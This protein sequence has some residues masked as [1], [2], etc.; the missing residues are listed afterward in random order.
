MSNP[1]KL[2][3]CVDDLNR[4]I[5]SRKFLKI[6][7]DTIYDKEIVFGSKYYFKSDHDNFDIHI[8]HGNL[9][10]QKYFGKNISKY[11]ERDL[12]IFLL[13][14]IEW[15]LRKYDIKCVRVGITYYIK[16]EMESDSYVIRQ[17][18]DK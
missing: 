18:R 4:W 7:K 8:F 13:E 1:L 14:H 9:F 15:I 11:S 12:I 16:Y 5:L 2:S 10:K 6:N 17:Q 3:Q